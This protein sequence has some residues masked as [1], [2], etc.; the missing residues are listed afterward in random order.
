MFHKCTYSD[1]SVK[2]ACFIDNE[3]IGEN[4]LTCNRKKPGETFQV[5]EVGGLEVGRTKEM[6]QTYKYFTYTED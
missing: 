1:L 6:P 5:K 4:K 3:N 2:Q